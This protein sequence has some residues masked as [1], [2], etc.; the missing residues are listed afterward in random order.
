MA[1]ENAELKAG[2]IKDQFECGKRMRMEGDIDALEQAAG[3]LEQQIKK[4]RADLAR[5]EEGRSSVALSSARG[6]ATLAEAA[7]AGE[8]TARALSEAAAAARF[9]EV[10]TAAATDAAAAA[11]SV[12]ALERKLDRE[13][14]QSR[15]VLN[16]HLKS[17]RAARAQGVSLGGLRG[18]LTRVNNARQE[19]RARFAEQGDQHAAAA[20]AAAAAASAASG[21][22][23]T[24]KRAEKAQATADKVVKR[25]KASTE[26]IRQRLAASQS[27]LARDRE[28]GKAPTPPL[29]S[30]ARRRPASPSDPPPHKTQAATP[31]RCSQS[32]NRPR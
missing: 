29:P 25:L 6:R 18:A 12:S 3:E 5:S 9:A 19:D 24:A 23:R 21:D 26:S 4:L 2:R 8:Q 30:P 10:V 20:T 31:L 32:P 7:L 13:Q 11:A 27:E 22:R 1:S 16:A 15:T 28:A 17:Q 14:T